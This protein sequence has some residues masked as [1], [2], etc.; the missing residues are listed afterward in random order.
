[1]Q[2]GARHIAPNW[3]DELTGHGARSTEGGSTAARLWFTLLLAS[4]TL[5]GLGRRFVPD[6]PAVAWYFAKDAV[7]VVGLAFLGL[8]R[9]ELAQARWL[10]RGFGVFLALAFVTTVL[11]IAN[12]QQT[13]L[14]LAAIGFKAY[15][16]W[17]L[18]P[19]VVAR[20]LRAPADREFAIRLLAV[21]AIGIAV[22][23]AAQFQLPGDARINQY[24]WNTEEMGIATVSQTGRVRVISTFSYMTGFTNFTVIALPLI[25]SL[26]L[27]EGRGWGKW[28]CLVAAGAIA[29]TIPMSGARTPVVLSVITVG[30]VF[31]VTGLLRTRAGR[32]I[33]IAAVVV[34]IAGW[35]GSRDA[36]EGV[37]SRFEDSQETE[38]RFVDGLQLFPPVAI[39][40]NDHPVLG[41]GTGMQQNARVLMRVNPV[42]NSEGEPGRYLIE[43]G[44]LGYL[45]V[46]LA[47]LGLAVA[48][49]RASRWARSAGRLSMAGLALAFVPLTFLG[50]LTFDHI[51][52][53]LYF[54][55]LG[56][57]LRDL[58][59]V[60][61]WPGAEIEN[62]RG[63]SVPGIRAT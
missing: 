19:V 46:W 34:A 48:L 23:A 6:I 36:V 21:V 53:A 7:L 20:A 1:M 30:I 42:W 33:G 25:L 62:H 55:G 61:P 15:W 41:I 2:R 24:A 47:R 26:G 5:E 40:V 27:G 50:N 56:L 39:A 13:S 17:W 63:P 14:A 58:V 37:R 38:G 52:Q 10:Y 29:V 12:P 28:L 11:Q 60:L 45:L 59:A 22:L 44:T 4:I 16:L 9:P 8:G 49:V 18:A 32:A 54:A 31:W 43:L 3:G 57:I 35:L 51:W